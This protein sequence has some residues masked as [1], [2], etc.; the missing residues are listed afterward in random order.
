MRVILD[1]GLALL[2][3]RLDAGHYEDAHGF[4]IARGIELGRDYDQK[5]GLSFSTY[6]RRILTLRLVDWYRATFGDARY[7]RAGRVTSFDALT[8]QDE[9]ADDYLDR[10]SPGARTDRIDELHRR[11]DPLEDVV[12]RAAIGL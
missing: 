7:D 11:A 3:A 1:R 5:R 2:G 8:H 4:L 12:S 10:H 9:D 6:S